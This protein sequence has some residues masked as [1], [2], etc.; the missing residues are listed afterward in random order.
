MT[1][2]SFPGHQGQGQGEEAVSAH[3]IVNRELTVP[4]RCASCLLPG[5]TELLQDTCRH[6]S[7]PTGHP[8]CFAA[9]CWVLPLYEKGRPSCGLGAESQDTLVPYILL[10]ARAKGD[11]EQ[12]KPDN[13]Q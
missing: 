12:T 9:L 7:M 6:R 8:L 10:S 2:Q 13:K 11:T 5:N 4:Q 1:R 3:Y